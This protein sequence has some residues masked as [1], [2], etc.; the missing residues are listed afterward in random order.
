MS[1]D[2][3]PAESRAFLF[4]L[5]LLKYNAYL[6]TNCC[7]CKWMDFTKDIQI[8]FPNLSKSFRKIY[9]M[10]FIFPFLFWYIG[11]LIDMSFTI[12]CKYCSNFAI[13]VW[14]SKSRFNFSTIYCIGTIIVFPLGASFPQL[15]ISSMIVSCILITLSLPQFIILIIS[16]IFVQ[17]FVGCLIIRY[18]HY[19]HTFYAVE[20]A[21]QCH[22]RM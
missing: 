3:W 21:R 16:W 15:W 9:N 11:I 8:F 1:K 10:L 4:F 7:R 14:Y 22:C 19:S 20:F 17:G 18:R 5:H 12:T 6:S 13:Y 2:A